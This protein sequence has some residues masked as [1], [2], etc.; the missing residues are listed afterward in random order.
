MKAKMGRPKVP[1]AKKRGIFIVTRVS[2]DESQAINSA[3]RRAGQSQS[4]WA[5]K[6]LLSAAGSDKPAS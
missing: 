3:I 1:K 2:P 5:R 6:A 4:E